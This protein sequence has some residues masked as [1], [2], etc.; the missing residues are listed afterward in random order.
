MLTSPSSRV[1][2]AAAAVVAAQ[3]LPDPPP[4]YPGPYLLHEVAPA[5]PTAWPIGAAPAATAASCHDVPDDG[6]AGGASAED[7]SAG[8]PADHGDSHAEVAV[9][10]TS[11]DRDARLAVV[12]STGALGD[13]DDGRAEAAIAAVDADHGEGR[14][15][16]DHD[17]GPAVGASADGPADHGGHHDRQDEAGTQPAAPGA[18]AAAAA[19]ATAPTTGP[20]GRVFG[21]DQRDDG[22]S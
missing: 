10:A 6:R 4:A 19:S 9:T 16:E 8:G 1:A 11:A 20:A 3:R 14:V 18:A 5:P 15:P 2:P 7:A 17:D 22:G 13:L 21:C 12:V